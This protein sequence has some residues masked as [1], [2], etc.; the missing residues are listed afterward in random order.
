MS[1][2]AYAEV[3]SS[4]GA[5]RLSGFSSTCTLVLLLLC[6]L[7][8]TGRSMSSKEQEAMAK[9]VEKAAVEEEQVEEQGEEDTFLVWGKEK[10]G[11]RRERIARDQRRM[12]C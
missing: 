7:L 3:K 5:A 8:S 10:R 11:T 4:L 9:V 12:F 6:A 1:W 2:R